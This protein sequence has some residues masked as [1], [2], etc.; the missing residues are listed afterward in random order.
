MSGQNK[1]GNES[2]HWYRHDDGQRKLV[3]QLVRAGI[4]SSINFGPTKNKEKR[5]DSNVLHY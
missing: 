1:M 2:T 4:P 5:S 3:S